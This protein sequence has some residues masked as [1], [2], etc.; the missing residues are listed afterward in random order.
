[1][2]RGTAGKLPPKKLRADHPRHPS[3]MAGGQPDSS[4][5]E[6]DADGEE[7]ETETSWNVVELHVSSGSGG[8][9]RRSRVGLVVR[10]GPQVK[11]N[12]LTSSKD[13]EEAKLIVNM[14]QTV[15]S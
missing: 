15:S 13:R 14:V 5:S 7:Q 6:P 3:T 1:M 8:T 2:T 10:T 9:R 4:E 11:R 12:R